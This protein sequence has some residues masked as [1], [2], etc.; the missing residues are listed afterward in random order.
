MAL[1]SIIAS[2]N[3]V[4][5]TYIRTTFGAGA[6][7]AA[8]ST[9]H[10]VLF[11]NKY[12]TGSTMTV[13]TEYDCY[14]IDEA[15]ALAGNG[16][17]LACMAEQALTANPGASIKLIAVTESAGTKA[18]AT[19]IIGGTT[20]TTAG[21][22]E[23]SVRGEIIEIGFAAG[24]AIAA[25]ATAV[26]DAINNK[27]FWPVVASVSTATVTVTA[28]NFGPRGNF[29]SL[30][31]RIIESGTGITS[32]ASATYLGSG[33]TSDD[34]Q[35]ALDV[36]AAL[37]RTFLA[38]PYA[39]STQIA[40]FKSHVDAQDE[41]EVGNRK[42]VVFASHDTIANVTTLATGVN[43]QRVD[44]IWMRNSDM[45]PAEISAGICA[46]RAGQD[47]T[48]PRFNYDGVQI[49][50][51]KPHYN[52]ADRPTNAQLKAALNNG[53]TPLATVGAGDVAIVRG[54]TSKS[55]DSSGKPDYRVLD[56]H[57]VTV[58]DYGADIFE[59][60]YSD[61]FGGF[62]A[63]DDAKDDKL[64]PDL[65]CTP[66]MVR[67]L[68]FEVL[69]AMEGSGSDSLGII[70]GLLDLGSV[71]RNAAQVIVELSKIS[72][73]RFNIS[74]PVDVIELAHQFAHDIRQV[75]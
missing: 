36:E 65:V 75:G 31:T 1:A 57:K 68:V 26:R 48:Q 64:P 51:F 73:G 28:K 33:A 41:P 59:I 52:S 21:T 35:T 16:G 34:P 56:W 11:G 30:R 71:E 62:A 70:G 47:S 19:V 24:D 23:V 44:C 20:A 5:G 12:A 39:D 69:N 13:E 14:S 4:P 2:D 6:R 42:R 43:F 67:D 29:I 60:V 49:P 74:S 63:S 22:V 40:K 66:K 45:T 25:I 3:K 32:T 58:I 38:C 18:N 27:T 7:S 54:I 8:D 53:I 37:R 46:F 55:Q 9:K 50:G 17:E 61:R 72:Q 15:R 10:V